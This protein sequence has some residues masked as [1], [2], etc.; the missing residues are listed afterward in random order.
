MRL[1]HSPPVS[2]HRPYSHAL[3][4]SRAGWS[5]DH[6]RCDGSWD[7][8]EFWSS[9][10]NICY[11]SDIWGR[12]GTLASLTEKI[13]NHAESQPEGSLLY[14]RKFLGLGN[15]DAIDQALSRLARDGKLM[16]LCQGI[17]AQPVQTRFG[18]RPPRLQRVIDSLADL[19]GHTIVSSGGLLAN[20]FGLTTQVPVQPVFLTSGPSRKLT[21]GEM[22]VDI[23]HAPNWQLVAPHTRVGDAVRAVAWMGAEEAERSW[24]E[25]QRHLM[26]GDLEY[27]AGAP[28][29][30]PEWVVGPVRAMVSDA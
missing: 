7:R 16:R 14:A 20:S 29:R 30:V 26:P 19:W 18:P 1:L 10:Q 5:R 8:C 12:N 17:Y 23:Q 2:T 11:I 25:I 21:L 27:V 3:C 28:A 22:R 9:G 13:I 4:A 15:R 6:H 24:D